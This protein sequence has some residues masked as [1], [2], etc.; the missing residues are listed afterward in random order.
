MKLKLT[1]AGIIVISIIFVIFSQ[2]QRKEKSKVLGEMVFE[3]YIP[4]EKI[5]K[6]TPSPEYT[7]SENKE[8]KS[9]PEAGILEVIAEKIVEKITGESPNDLESLFEKYSSEY[10]VD[11]NLLKRIAD[12]ESEFNPQAINGS[13][14][15]LYQFTTS[16]WAVTRKSM[17][18]SEDEKERFNAEEAIRT[19]AFKISRGGLSAWPNCAN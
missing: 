12:C 1:I 9:A 8:I 2:T 19:A 18:M 3:K 14:G 4:P 17:G 10:K 11:K 5:K 6:V 15:G 7:L 16:T 13:Y